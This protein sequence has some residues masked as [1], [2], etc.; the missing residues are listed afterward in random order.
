[1]DKDS[2]KWQRAAK[3]ILDIF[4]PNRCPFCDE[5]IKWD[6][7]ICDSCKKVLPLTGDKLCIRCGKSP[8]VCDENLQ[9][10][11]CFTACYY[12][13][14][15]VEGVLG[16]KTKNALNAAEIFGAILAEKIS[17]WGKTPTTGIESGADKALRADKIDIIT[18]VPMT[19][20]KQSLRGYNQAE[21]IA[22]LVSKNADIPV[23]VNILFKKDSA[24][25]HTLNAKER[26][27]NVKNEFY[28]GN[29]MLDGKTVLLC[30]DVMTTGST[31]NECA[32]ILKQMGAK[33]VFI[34]VGAV[35]RLKF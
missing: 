28:G 29:E 18:F 11:R 6:L 34:A 5:I 23:C 8:C 1:M 16:L 15:A 32:R 21:E 12:E 17:A 30:D 20:K 25:Q 35:T 7:I 13:G 3:F 2:L 19:R 31:V 27:E 22:K 10:D 4:F 14:V 24:A 26:A 9:Y 33:N